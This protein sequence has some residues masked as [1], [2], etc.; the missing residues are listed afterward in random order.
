M[1]QGSAQ[2]GI[3]AIFVSA[4]GTERMR[5]KWL[6]GIG[7][8]L[9]LGLAMSAPAQQSGSESEKAV[10]ALENM[11]LQSEKVNNPD[12]VT[13]IFSDRYVA[14]GPDG[15]L[16]DKRQTLADAKARKWSSSEYEDVKVRVFG[17]TAIVTG[18]YKG[19]GTEASGKPFDEHLR[20]TDTWVRMPGSKWLLV[21]SHYSAVNT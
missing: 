14:T 3:W 12:L 7:A 21:A 1:R 5:N 19:T 13:S 10:L 18:G 17:D 9:A 2:N 8:L 4:W 15:K 16:E 20:W 11:W 6:C